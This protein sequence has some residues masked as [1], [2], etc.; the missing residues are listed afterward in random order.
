MA[1]SPKAPHVYYGPKDPETGQMVEP[2]YTHQEYPKML[3]LADEEAESG[4]V[5]KTA[6]DE[7]EHK[8]LEEQ[9][10]VEDLASLDIVTCPS[11]EQIEAAKDAERAAKRGGDASERPARKR[12]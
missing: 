3:Y 9:G 2:T 8:A 12:K 4:F 7:A 1:K 10:Y 6:K 5:H 11:T